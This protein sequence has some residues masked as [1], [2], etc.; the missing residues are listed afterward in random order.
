MNPEIINLGFISI[1]WYSALILIGFIVGYYLVLNECNYKGIQK[2]VINDICF[3]LVIISIIGAR[4]Y[5]CLFNLDYYGSNLLDIL[6]IWEGGL[7][8]HGGIIAVLIYLI[9]ESK[10]RKIHFLTL[11]DLFAPSLALGQV[12]GRWGNFFNGEAYGPVTT[13]TNLKNLHIPKFIIDGMYINGEYHHPTFLYESIG[14]LIIFIILMIIR[15]L[16]E[17]K[18][19]IIISTY[20]ILYG[21]IRFFIESLRTDSLIIINFKVAQIVS[22]LMTI[23]GIYILI[24]VVR[25]KYDKQEMGYSIKR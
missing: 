21:I 19:G 6:K 22:I 20:F 12:I 11:L 7:A 16:N 9:Y 23:V 8:I 4:L 1:R 18:R 17:K 14:C 25:G 5:Y 3:N 24:N 13:I 15:K 10:K 2:N